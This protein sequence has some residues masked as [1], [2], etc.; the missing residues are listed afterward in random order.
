MSHNQEGIHCSEYTNGCVT[1][2]VA[3]IAIALLIVNTN[4]NIAG[5][6]LQ[7]HLVSRLLVKIDTLLVLEY[8]WKPL[9]N[10]EETMQ[11]VNI[12]PYPVSSPECTLVGHPFIL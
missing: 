9:L 1:S 2:C 11:G 3:P 6:P 12:L 7:T 5:Y 10:M 8:Y 4:Y